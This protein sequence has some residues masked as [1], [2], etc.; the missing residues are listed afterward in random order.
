M[1][2]IV[3]V[4]VVDCIEDLTDCLSSVLLRKFSLFANT[5]EQL[6]TSGQLGHNVVL[7]L[8]LVS[9]TNP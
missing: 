5:V 1:D 8:A 2:H 9:P 7:V 3:L 4:E 6:S